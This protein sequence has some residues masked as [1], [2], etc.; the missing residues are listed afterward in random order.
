[1][2]THINVDV[3]SIFL[4]INCYCYN[5]ENAVLDLSIESYIQIKFQSVLKSQLIFFSANAV[6]KLMIAQ[7]WKISLL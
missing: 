2:Y 1:V 5:T 4:T 6:G 7:Y 3:D